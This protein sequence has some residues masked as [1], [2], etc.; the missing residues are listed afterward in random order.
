MGTISFSFIVLLLDCLDRT[1]LKD[2]SGL[3]WALFHALLG[4]YF[5]PYMICRLEVSHHCH[6]ALLTCNARIGDG[7]ISH[8]IDLLVFEILKASQQ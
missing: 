4:P 7:V 6:K 5:R 3:I 1:R 2:F 8:I